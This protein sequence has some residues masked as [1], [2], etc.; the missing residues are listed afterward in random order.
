MAV[1]ATWQSCS[2]WPAV[3]AA[4]ALWDC[5]TGSVLHVMG[6]VCKGLTLVQIDQS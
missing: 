2:Y 4:V 5:C 1:A 3:M 6:C